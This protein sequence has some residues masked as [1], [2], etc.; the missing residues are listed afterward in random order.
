M[1]GDFMKVDVTNSTVQILVEL[2]GQV[3][4]VAMNKDR[5]EA[6]SVLIRSSIETLIRT[7]KTQEEFIEFVDWTDRQHE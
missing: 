7:G 1:R 5:Y 4:L 3:H 2:D 6:I